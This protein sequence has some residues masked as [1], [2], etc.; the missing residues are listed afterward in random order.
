MT[1]SCPKCHALIEVDLSHIP[2]DGTLRPC[3]ECKGRFWINR[4]SYARVALKKEGK[5]YC[6]KCGNELEHKIVCNECG[7]MY[8]DYYLV[9][10]SKP[11]RRQVEKPDLFSLSFT[12]QP[13]TPTYSQT[14]TY[15]GAKESSGKSPKVLLK[16]VGLLALVVLLALGIAKLY[17]IKQ[18]EK[19]YAKNYM[20]A[21]YTIKTGTDLSLDTCA[22]ISAEWKTKMDAGQ[23][24]APRISADDES[25]L[26]KVKD[27]ADRYLQYLNEPP[28]KFIDS[29]EKLVNL[30]GV[31]AKAHALAV[32]PTGSLPG[33][34]TSTTNSQSEFNVAVKDLKGSLSP[35]LSEELQV[36]KVIYKGLKNI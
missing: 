15:M 30:Y 13:A 33:F 5:T 28:K 10:A 29:K 1:C 24:Y 4:E 20:R 19:Q 21:L 3:P 31:Y 12:L 32:A 17:H 9:Q 8:P 27:A 11:P 23:N 16:R 6:D 22:K 34:T 36:A 14:Y 25:R 7:V 35:E 2:E 26:N 18:V